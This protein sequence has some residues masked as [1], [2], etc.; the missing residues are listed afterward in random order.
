MGSTGTQVCR[1]PD[2]LK[3]CAALAG[4]VVFSTGFVDGSAFGSGSSQ[5]SVLRRCLQEL[6]EF[7]KSDPNAVLVF[8][9]LLELVRDALS[10]AQ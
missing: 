3:G 9:A 7:F 5:N 10:R 8:S 4:G 2:V 6:I 1:V